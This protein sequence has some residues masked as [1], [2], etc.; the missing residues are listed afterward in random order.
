MGDAF[1]GSGGLAC[2]VTGTHRTFGA[3][4]AKDIVVQPLS[5]SG[6]RVNDRRLPEADACSLRGF[7]E[8]KDQR[9]EVLQLTHG[10]QW[11]TF[12][13]L[14]EALTQFSEPAEGAPSR[15]WEFSP[16]PPQRRAARGPVAS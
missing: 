2:T 8:E 12:P 14:A 9:F 7:I 6:W 15:G 16:P 11:F 1:F 10:C 13:S 3:A 5:A 4:T